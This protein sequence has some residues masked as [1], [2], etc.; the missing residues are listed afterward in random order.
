LNDQ[1]AE[2]LAHLHSQR[3]VHRDIKPHNIL[4]AYPDDGAGSNKNAV[5]GQTQNPASIT[6]L[7]D[8]GTSFVES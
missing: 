2:G 4:C 8:L 5:Q 7:R 6:S 3:I 1:V